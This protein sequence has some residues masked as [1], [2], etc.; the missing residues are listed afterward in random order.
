MDAT[1]LPSNFASTANALE[2]LAFTAKDVLLVVDDFVPTGGAGDN[3]LQGVAERLF[4]AAGN[5]QGRSRMSGNGHLRS[6]HPPRALL[7]ATGEE[8][9]RG[10]SLRARLL[11][12]E[13]APGDVDRATLNECQQAGQQGI[14]SSAMG[15]YL[16][17]IA[18]R[19]EEIQRRLKARAQELQ[20]LYSDA[21]HARLPG[22]LAELHSGFEI[23]LQFAL[24]VGSIT[25]TEHSQLAQRNGAALHELATLQTKFHLASDPAV[26]FLSLLRAALSSGHAHVADRTG[27]TPESPECWG[28]RRKLSNRTW[29]PQ[30][31]RVGWLTGSDLFLD[32]ILSYQIV[33]QIAGAERLPISEQTLRHRLNEGACSPALTPAGQC[34]K[35]AAPWAV[36]PDK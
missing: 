4:R 28:W 35:Y 26:R 33:Q 2:S 11:I 17:W 30:G 6:S 29:I 23:W 12:V 31:V 25:T 20:N 36:E 3:V 18:G 15:A 13:V 16:N 10:Q 24:E 9:P 5:R 32:P 34:C 8:V 7:L 27:K 22:T 21:V 19:Y 1:R 14:L